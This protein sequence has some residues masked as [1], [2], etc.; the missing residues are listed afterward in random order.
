MTSVMFWERE[1]QGRQAGV[2]GEAVCEPGCG[3]GKI[4]T[5]GPG[6][7]GRLH[8]GWYFLWSVYH[9]FLF[10]IVQALQWPCH[11]PEWLI[12][13]LLADSGW[14]RGCSWLQLWVPVKR[15]K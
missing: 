2:E 3:V 15:T 12:F 7:L 4:L 6:W 10:A 11:G 8:P 14:N 1:S 13:S 5:L 9:C